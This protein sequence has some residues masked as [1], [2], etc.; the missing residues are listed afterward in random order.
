LVDRWTLQYLKETW[1]AG[2]C[3]YICDGVAKT[4]TRREKRYPM[5][6]DLCAYR[7]DDLPPRRLQLFRVESLPEQIED[8]IY[9]P[10]MAE[11]IDGRWTRMGI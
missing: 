3:S 5:V 9:F 4:I 7:E 6:L 1:Y 11:F 10:G 2:Y 8:G